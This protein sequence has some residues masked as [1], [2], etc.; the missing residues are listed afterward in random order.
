M[1]VWNVLMQYTT[2]AW[3]NDNICGKCKRI[4]SNTLSELFNH[5]LKDLLI[6]SNYVNH[7]TQ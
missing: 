4:V 7:I 1:E 6:C 2:N 5:I 3:R